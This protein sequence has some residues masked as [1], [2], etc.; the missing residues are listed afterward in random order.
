VCIAPDLGQIN[1]LNQIIRKLH[2]SMGVQ[3]K[4]NNIKLDILGITKFRTK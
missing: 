1:R 3:F 2:V 4:T